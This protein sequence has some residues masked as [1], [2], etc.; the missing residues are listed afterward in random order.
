MFNSSLSLCLLFQGLASLCGSHFGGILD[1]VMGIQKMHFHSLFHLFLFLLL[2]QG[3]AS[4]RG[5]HFG[6]SLD[7]VMGMQKKRYPD[8]KL[9]WIQTTLSE[10]VLRLNGAQTEGIFRIPGEIGESM[11]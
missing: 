10:E 2:S 5:S 11:I 8:R 3:L 7:D 9:P 4:L 6:G 1:Y